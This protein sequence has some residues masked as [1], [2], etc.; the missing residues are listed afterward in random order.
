LFTFSIAQVLPDLT[1]HL[2]I[3]SV[4]DVFDFCSASLRTECSWLRQHFIAHQEK[5]NTPA[6]RVR[7]FLLHALEELQPQQQPPEG[8]SVSRLAQLLRLFCGVCGMWGLRVSAGS[9]GRVLAAIEAHCMRS[10]HV[11]QQGLCFLLVCEGLCKI[12]SPQAVSATIAALMNSSAKSLAIL[13]GV[14]F[15]AKNLSLNAS[16]AKLG[17]GLPVSIHSDSMQQLGNVWRQ[18]YAEPLLAEFALTMDPVVDLREG[19]GPE[20]A[21]GKR[22]N[23]LI[24]VV[25]VVTLLQ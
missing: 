24:F 6:A 22:Q 9:S 1:L 17:V 14:R 7:G 8:V 5:E 2:T 25:F 10:H 23:N 21:A 20:D 16:W 3:Q 15:N 11:A 18:L 13:I 19:M 4:R 12:A